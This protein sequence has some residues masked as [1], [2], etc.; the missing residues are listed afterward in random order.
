[1]EAVLIKSKCSVK[2]GVGQEVKVVVSSLISKSE[3]AHAAGTHIP[4]VSIYGY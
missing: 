4:L 1:M 3:K 2:A